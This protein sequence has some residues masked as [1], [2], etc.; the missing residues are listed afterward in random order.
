MRHRDSCSRV[1]LGAYPLDARTIENWRLFQIKQIFPVFQRV[2]PNSFNGFS[3]RKLNVTRSNKYFTGNKEV[4]SEM[5]LYAPR[6]RVELLCLI[7]HHR[8]VL[9]QKRLVPVLDFND[10]HPCWTNCEQIDII[11]SS[12]RLRRVLEV[13][14]ENPGSVEPRRKIIQSFLFALGLIWSTRNMLGR[15]EPIP[16]WWGITPYFAGPTTNL[17]AD[18]SSIDR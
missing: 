16:F 7:D 4:D 17:Q 9:F 15:H 8:G 12:S 14:K 11:G 1:Y 18:P 3:L 6:F 10:V 13:S 2:E 5:R